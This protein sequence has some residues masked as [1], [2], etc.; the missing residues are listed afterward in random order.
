M[1]RIYLDYAATTP[2]AS[3]V[4]AAMLP[5]FSDRFGNPASMHAFGQENKGAVEE[6]RERIASFLGA[7]PGEIVFTSGGTES[8]NTAVKG[9][10]YA[11]QGKGNHIITSPIEH[12]AVLE[13]CHFLEKEGFEI[14]ILP[15]D[16]DGLVD[17][18]DVR[19]T[20]TGKTILIS[21]MHANNEIG[22]IQPIEEIGRIARER[23]VYFHT[24]AVQT[25][26]HLPFT[27]GELHVDLL[28]ASAHK[29]YGPKGV[30]ILFV[31]KGT[32]LTP[33]MHGGEQENRRRASTHN[34]PGIVGFA[35][36]VELASEGME[37]EVRELT[38]LRDRLITGLREGIEAVKLNGHSTRRLPNNVNIS[39][40]H[41]EG[42][43]LLL[44]L[45]MLGIAC[46]TG[47]ACSSAS[48]EPSHVLMA[49]GLPHEL[50][51]G[52]L[53]FSLGRPT[54]AADIDRLLAVLPPVV[55]RLRAM[56]PLYNQQNK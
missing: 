56:S 9:V 43:G 8:N 25:L 50:A 4:V 44:S 22:T 49:L 35:K 21:V 46:S 18:D 40:A 31:K 45:D 48:L 53:R 6:A 41:V 37:T 34:V 10:A 5:F 13:P 36:A 19:K 1:E 29:L 12:H 3:E 32:R 16:G 51:H 52:S 28:S 33:F 54:T 17:P 11:R 23:G 55:Q 39:V 38:A 26:G 24:D 7:A 20:I 2:C 27:V 15:V 30:G 14:T 42:E 47:S